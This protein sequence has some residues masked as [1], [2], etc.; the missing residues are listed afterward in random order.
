MINFNHLYYFYVTA[1]SA[2]TTLAASHLHISQP[3]LSSQL[4][5]LEG[6]FGMKLFRKVGRVN[7]LTEGGSIVYGFARRMFEVSEELSELILERIPS[8]ARR[9]TIG[10]S[11]EVERSF[12]VEV[13]S[14]F[15]KKQ[16]AKQRPK[17]TMVSG[18]HDQLVERLRFRELDAVVTQLPMSDPDLMSL[19]RTESPVAL[20]C[21]QEWKKGVKSLDFNSTDSEWVMPS[22]KF[23]L[24]AEIDRFFETHELKGRVIFESDVIASLVRSV[25]D[26][27]GI[28]IGIVIRIILV[29]FNGT[30][31]LALAHLNNI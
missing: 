29:S 10:V 27:I 26:E 20:V 4:K 15:L 31:S 11:D 23:K 8:A 7:Q 19:M 14:L 28:S 22:M 5:L 21:S 16:G 2:S 24:R 1:K 12:A 13:V 18:S 9:I 17:V 30:C 3:S 6:A 25:A